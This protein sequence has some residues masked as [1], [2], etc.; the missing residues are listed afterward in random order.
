[1]VFDNVRKSSLPHGAE[2]QEEDDAEHLCGSISSSSLSLVLHS[3]ACICM[4]RN[5]GFQVCLLS[6][7]HIYRHLNS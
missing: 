2:C 1:M 4:E 7:N 5:K 3:G 6:G